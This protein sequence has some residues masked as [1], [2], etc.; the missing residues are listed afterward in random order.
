MIRFLAAALLLLSTS[1][2]AAQDVV[3][4]PSLGTDLA[5]DG[6]L[7]RAPGPGRHPA[8][9]FMHGC[10]G[11]FTR[12][13]AIDPRLRDWAN[14][15]TASGKSVVMVDS[16]GPRGVT[17]MCAPKT[18][19]SAVAEARPAD[20]YGALLYLQAQDFVLPD[21]VGLIGWSQGGGVVLRTVRGPG[22]PRPAALPGGDFRAAAAFYPGSCNPQTLRAPWDPQIPL[23][24]LTGAKDVWTPIA[25]CQA[26]ADGARARG[27]KVEIITYPDAVHDFDAPYMQVREFPQYRTSAGVVPILGT[28]PAAR[29]DAQQRLPAFF[30]EYLR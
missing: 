8:L 6:Y 12:A 11:M 30:A 17:N 26:L 3:H 20:A 14:I 19:E 27:D 2:A 25:P 1:L 24:I 15:F 18:Y 7:F 9:V 4:F 29:A 5:L 10:G 21:R 23:L 22:S 13:R 16:F 28:D